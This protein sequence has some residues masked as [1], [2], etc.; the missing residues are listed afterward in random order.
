MTLKYINIDNISIRK[1]KSEKFKPR[2]DFWAK[3]GV[4]INVPIHWDGA[5]CSVPMSSF[6]CLIPNTIIIKNMKFNTAVKLLKANG[7]N[8]C[9]INTLTSD[10]TFALNKVQLGSQPLMERCNLPRW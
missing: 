3:L 7:D 9:P 1:Q 8:R 10:L 6:N 5:L 4:P 2:M